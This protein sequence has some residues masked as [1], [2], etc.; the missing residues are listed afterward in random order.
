MIRKETRYSDNSTWWL[1]LDR[2]SLSSNESSRNCKSRVFYKKNCPPRTTF[3]FRHIARF[4][5]IVVHF[6]STKSPIISFHLWFIRNRSNFDRVNLH[7]SN[8]YSTITKSETKKKTSFVKIKLPRIKI[9]RD[10]FS[11]HRE[12]S[13]IEFRSRQITIRIRTGKCSQHLQIFKWKLEKIKI[14][15]ALSREVSA[16]GTFRL[17]RNARA[18]CE[19]SEAE[20]NVISLLHAYRYGSLNAQRASI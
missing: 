16:R 9:K 2:V 6:S 3:F 4:A 18:T 5:G 19:H 14:Q 1:F 15:A 8:F 20:T 13:V 12:A 10:V 17:W 7:S 11:R